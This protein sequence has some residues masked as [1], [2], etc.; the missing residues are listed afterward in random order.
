MLL[1]LLSRLLYPRVI[2]I[3]IHSR[4]NDIPTNESMDRSP[5]VFI[6]LCASFLP[7]VDDIHETG[8]DESVPDS[9]THEA[10]KLRV[11]IARDSTNVS[12][13]LGCL[14]VSGM[15]SIVGMMGGIVSD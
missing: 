10:Y 9:G 14:V 13:A 4:V 3:I 7:E 2:H 12:I 6:L 15:M 1:V 11:M 5:S 8:E